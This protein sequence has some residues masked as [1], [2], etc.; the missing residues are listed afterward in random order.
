MKIS[1]GELAAKIQAKVIGNPDAVIQFFSEIEDCENVDTLV[2]AIDKKSIKKLK[3]YQPK[4][5]VL[6][7]DI[8]ELKAIKL[9]IKKD[10][11]ILIDLLNIFYPEIQEP[12]ISPK[13]FINPSAKLGSGVKIYPGVFIGAN[14]TVGK[15][16]VIY[17]NAV[18]YDNCL[19]GSGCIIHS[20]A[21][22]GADGF[23]FIQ[24]D[25]KNL[26]VPQKGRVELGNDV[27][28]GAGTTID[29]AT[30]K[31][32]VIGEG[33]KIDNKVQIGHN[34]KIGKNCILVGGANIGGSAVLEDNVIIAGGAGVVDNITI[35]RNSVVYA[36]TVATT[37]Y[38][39]NSKIYATPAGDDY[40]TAMKRRAAYN[41]LPEII[42]QLKKNIK[43]PKG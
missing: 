22:L 25:G 34:V 11:E 5:V 31:A 24:K 32:T 16:T 36:Y 12:F 37:D 8:P 1:A 39:P 23:G 3:K 41:Q 4:I 19:I 21:V 42:A 33:T 10:K 9:I 7:A 29:R 35:G 40:L 13:A 27:E 18:I 28:I 6:N 26:K 20:N 14:V 15:D 2:L 30:I 43:K 17:P 38:P